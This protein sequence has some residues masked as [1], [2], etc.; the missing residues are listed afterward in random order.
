MLHELALEILGIMFHGIETKA[1]EPKLAGDPTTP[2]KYIMSDSVLGVIYV[3]EH[4]IVV[5][6][7]FGVHVCGPT[8]LVTTGKLVDGVGMRRCIVVNAREVLPVIFLCA[9]LVAASRKVETCPGFNF[10]W[11]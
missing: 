4:E 3:G 8:R 10:N 2:V 5:I 7:K 1:G 9:M 6:T 11:R